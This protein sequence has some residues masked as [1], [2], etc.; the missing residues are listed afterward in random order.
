MKALTRR[1]TYA[2]SAK[3]LSD[4]EC[5][6]SDPV[7]LNKCALH[8]CEFASTDLQH[9]FLITYRDGVEIT[10]SFFKVR[11]FRPTASLDQTISKNFLIKFL[12]S[13]DTKKKYM[14]DK[15]NIGKME[16][17]TMSRIVPECCGEGI[18]LENIIKYRVTNE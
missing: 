13:K 15:L 16:N 6:Y 11:V 9:N 4:F 18:N 12:N 7:R 14:T 8:S 1:D 3:C 10:K 2:R 17:K 5:D